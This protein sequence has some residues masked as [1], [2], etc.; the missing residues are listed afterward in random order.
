LERVGL[1]VPFTQHAVVLAQIV[2]SAPFFVRAAAAAFRE[3]DLDLL[4]VART[5]GAS[6]LGAFFRVAAGPTA[7]VPPWCASPTPLAR[8]PTSAIPIWAS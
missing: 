7:C 8:A 1:S 2:V 6:S 4:I 5:L 3:I